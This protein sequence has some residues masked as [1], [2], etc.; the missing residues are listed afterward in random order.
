[1]ADTEVASPLDPSNDPTRVPDSSLDPLFQPKTRG[2]RSNRQGGQRPAER[3]CGTSSAIRSEAWCF[4]AEGAGN[5][6]EPEILAVG[7][8]SRTAPTEAEFSILV[9]DAHQG[10]GLGSELL[11]RLVEIGRK[12]GLR[13][14]TAEMSPAN[15]AMQAVSRKLGFEIRGELQDPTTEA[16]LQL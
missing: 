14:I 13:R 1:M 10:Q 8:L 3:C 11:R 9:A 4:P 12:E 6:G 16:V 7:R 15:G 5:S 2:D